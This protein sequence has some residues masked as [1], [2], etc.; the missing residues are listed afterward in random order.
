VLDGELNMFGLFSNDGVRFVLGYAG[1]ADDG[2]HFEYDENDLIYDSAGGGWIGVDGSG[3]RVVNERIVDIMSGTWEDIAPAMDLVV[4]GWDW[5]TDWTVRQE[6]V[7]KKDLSDVDE[8][9]H[10]HV[11]DLNN[12]H[13][14]TKEQV[15]LGNADNTS[16]ED[17]PVSTAQQTAI[18]EKAKKVPEAPDGNFPLFYDGDLEDSGYNDGSFVKSSDVEGSLSGTAG[19][20]PDSAAVAE[21]LAEVIGRDELSAVLVDCRINNSA[22]AVTAVF[23]VYNPVTKESTEETRAFPIASESNPGQMPKESFAS[24][25]QAIADIESLKA[26]G[27]RWITQNFATKAALD[28]FTVPPSVNIGDWT[29][30]LEDETRDGHHT[31]YA[32]V[33]GDGTKVFAY[34]YDVQGDSI[35]IAGTGTSGVVQGVADDAVNAG[36]IFAETDGSMSVIG[37]D[38]LVSR[39]STLE[40]WKASHDGD[41]TRH[42]TDTERTAWN[43][44]QAAL[45]RTVGGDDN[46]TGTVSDTGGNLSIPIPV[47]VAAPSASTAQAA[48]GTKTLREIIQTLI[49][50]I[51]SLFTSVD[52]KVDAVSGKGLSTNDFDATYKAKLDFTGSQT[53]T[54]LASIAV[55][56]QIVTATVSTNQALSIAS[57]SVENAAFVVIIKATA[58]ITVALPDGV[59]YRNMYGASLAVTSGGVAIVHLFYNSADSL[60]YLNVEETTV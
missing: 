36:K 57:V 10:A 54:S 12:P 8:A 29:D 44:K 45:S 22:T 1:I 3:D 28:A 35:G 51:A 2:E 7:I 47:T 13:G 31:R 39:M 49:N 5:A 40:S 43:A 19:K 16:D 30:V 32:I 46:A 60:Y 17:K 56:K 18:R 42:I 59:G 6:S 50:N 9:L 20:I 37:W 33:G 48:A 11:E 53:V 4:S 38:D 27:G 34:Q 26:A 25:V 52:S 15:G 55:T 21:K 41:N 14:V 23:S 24:L 58:D